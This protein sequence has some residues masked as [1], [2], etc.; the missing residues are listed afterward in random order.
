MEKH[1]FDGDQEGFWNKVRLIA[2]LC[3]DTYLSMQFAFKYTI[4]SDD[5]Y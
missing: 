1:L 2:K 5:E 4:M 3:L